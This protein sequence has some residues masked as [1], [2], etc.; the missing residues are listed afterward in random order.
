MIYIQVFDAPTGEEL[1][2]GPVEKVDVSGGVPPSI[3]S[4]LDEGN[5]KEMMNNKLDIAQY[6]AGRGVKKGNGENNGE[7]QKVASH[8]FDEIYR[9]IRWYERTDGKR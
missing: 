5:R 8:C 6:V 1:E 9:I 2:E 7:D 4:I 3:V